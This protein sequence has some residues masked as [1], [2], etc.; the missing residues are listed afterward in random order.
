[1]PKEGEPYGPTTRSLWELR[2][3]TTIQIKG[4]P[5]RQI[6]EHHHEI[7]MAAEEYEAKVLQKVKIGWH[8]QP[9][10]DAPYICSGIKHP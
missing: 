5:R 9:I 10:I 4:S 8:H 3:Y 6:T 1:M 7:T 2:R